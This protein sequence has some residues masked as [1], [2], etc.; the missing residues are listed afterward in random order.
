MGGV[1]L[2]TRLL[3]V[4]LLIHLRFV[5][6]VFASPLFAATMSPLPFRYLC[7]VLLTVVSIGAV[8][9]EVSVMLFENPLSLSLLALREILVGIAIGLLASLPLVA[10][11]VAGEQAGMAMGFSMALVVDP[12][13]QSQGSV[14]GQLYFLVGMWFYFRWNGHLL[15]VRSV[16]ESLTLVPL[17]RL[18]PFPSGD[19]SLG[20]WVQGLFV[21][22][23]RIVIPFY[24]A[25]VLADVGLGFLA[26]TVPQM[27]IFVLGLP[28]KVALGF[29]VLAVALPL[30]VD[31]IY[32][33]LERWIEFSLAGALVW[34][35]AP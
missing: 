6:M 11:R 4:Y 8:S 24:C 14:L 9:G 13:T 34:R 7:A 2:P 19:M 5:G 10:L 27:N 12:M 3:F 23:I 30:T 15:M 35:G 1:E 20:A 29:L 18:N 17:G 21:L 26:R 28:V 22:G 16:V 25:L 33:Q 32:A 31:L